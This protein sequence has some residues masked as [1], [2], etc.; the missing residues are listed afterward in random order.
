MEPEATGDLDPAE[1]AAPRDA[2]AGDAT[3]ATRQRI[4]EIALAR[5]EAYEE[6]AWHGTRWRVRNKTFAHVLRVDDKP[7]AFRRVLGGDRS[8]DVLSF[9]VADEDVELYRSLGPPF[10]V[11]GWGRNQ[12][13]LVLDRATDWDQVRELVVDSYRTVAPAALVRRSTDDDGTAD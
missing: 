3:P 6:Q 1:D 5:P 4:R 9:R 2:A 11:G 13:L 12:V 10:A 8:V 7:P